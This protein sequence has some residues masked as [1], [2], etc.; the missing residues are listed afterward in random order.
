MNEK[1]EDAKL[2]LSGWNKMNDKEKISFSKSLNLTKDLVS[3]YDGNIMKYNPLK[4]E[5]FKY[6]QK[7]RN[8]YKDGFC[9]RDTYKDSKRFEVSNQQIWDDFSLK[10]KKAL[11]VSYQTLL[12]NYIRTNDEEYLVDNPE[13]KTFCYYLKETEMNSLRWNKEKML[14]RCEDYRKLDDLFRK[15]YKKNKF[16]SNDSLREYFI[17]EFPKLYINLKPKSTLIESHNNIFTVNPV[18]ERIDGR[19]TR[20][21]RV[22][23]LKLMNNE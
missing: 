4:K 7:V 16:Y 19:M 12:K 21:Y 22:E 8:Q 15:I 20:G 2:K 1:E 11:V 9:V 10:V 6:M 3:I 17:N 23:N 14:A 18:R 13:F 5:Y